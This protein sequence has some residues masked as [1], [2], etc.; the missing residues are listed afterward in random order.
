MQYPEDND[1]AI[2]KILNGTKE[3]ASKEIELND[4]WTGFKFDFVSTS[5]NVSINIGFER[6]QHII[7]V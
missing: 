1:V 5:Q 2:L 6:G 7:C 4:G 3:I